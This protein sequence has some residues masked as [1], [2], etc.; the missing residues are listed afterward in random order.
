MINNDV[1]KPKSFL[2]FYCFCCLDIDFSSNDLPSIPDVIYKI[3]TLRRLNLSENKISDIAPNIDN[4]EELISLNFSRN[5]LK[6]LP[7]SVDIVVY[8]FLFQVI[9]II[10]SFS[11]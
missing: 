6:S 10:I 8:M 4:L 3:K 9:S 1:Y 5:Q 2:K 11:A 7:V